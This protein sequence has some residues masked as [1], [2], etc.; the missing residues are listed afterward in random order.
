[1]ATPLQKQEPGH[2]GPHPQT[3]APERRKPDQDRGV[4]RELPPSQPQAA[5]AAA[6]QPVKQ[7]PQQQQHPAAVAVQQQEQQPPAEPAAAQAAQEQTPQAAAGEPRSGVLHLQRQTAVRT[8]SAFLRRSPSVR[9][10]ALCAGP[11]PGPAAAPA[12]ATPGAAVPAVTTPPVQALPQSR[13]SS[14][15]PSGAGA[16]PSGAGSGSAKS[17]VAAVAPAPAATPPAALAAAGAWGWGTRGGRG[18]VRPLLVLW[19]GHLFH[20]APPAQRPLSTAA[21]CN[22]PHNHP[23]RRWLLPRAPRLLRQLAGRLPHGHWPRRARG[24]AAGRALG[25]RARGCSLP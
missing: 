22:R 21:P 8:H 13:G 11:S 4:L 18:A 5:A 15:P 19:T 9:P 20:T 14:S 10:P 6:K 23:L 1:V 12:A 24:A 17:E 25:R 3:A 16:A 7:E 2:A